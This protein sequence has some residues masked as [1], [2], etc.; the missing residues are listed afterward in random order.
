MSMQYNRRQFPPR[1][2]AP[3]LR[4]GGAP[5]Q[6]VPQLPEGYLKEGYFDANGNINCDLLTVEAEQVA[7][8]LGN[9]GMTSA[10]IRRFFG[11]VRSIERGLWT[12]D[13]SNIV[14]RI[15]SLQPLV[16][17]YVGRANNQWERQQRENMKRFIDRNVELATSNENSF[18]KGF[19]PHFESVVAYFK[20]HF[21]K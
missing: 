11:Q 18:K 20:Y 15:Q 14:P 10:Q 12:K 16:A 13:F 7:R 5:P 9:S 17:N 2:G 19:I 3:P 6:Q 21:P 1:S 8:V 4:R